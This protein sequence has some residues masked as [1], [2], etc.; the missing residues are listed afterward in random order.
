LPPWAHFPSAEETPS[1]VRILQS[2]SGSEG[3]RFIPTS[4][5]FFIASF[6]IFAV[7]LPL[8]TNVVQLGSAFFWS[9]SVSLGFWTPTV[10]SHQSDQFFYLFFGLPSV[11]R[12]DP[13][14][15]AEPNIHTGTPPFI[16]PRPFICPVYPFTSWLI[17]LPPR[18]DIHAPRCGVF[19]T[20]FFPGT[21]PCNR[22]PECIHST[23]LDI[24]LELC[25]VMLSFE[26]SPKSALFFGC[27]RGAFPLDGDMSSRRCFFLK[28]NTPPC[29]LSTLPSRPITLS[30]SVLLVLFFLSGT[31]LFSPR[32]YGWDFPHSFKSTLTFSLSGPTKRYP[33]N[34]KSRFAVFPPSP[35]FP[36]PFFLSPMDLSIMTGSIETFFYFFP[37][38]FFTCLR[39]L[40]RGFLSVCLERP[41]FSHP[42]RFYGCLYR[43]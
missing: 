7:W 22:F 16:S 37:P 1:S 10:V 42:A 41:F 21:H 5:V 18:K 29:F 33:I 17:F 36:P 30:R 13:P 23:F 15:N 43:A 40:P 28:K 34:L 2:P 12:K 27:P 4:G 9:P 25:C 14:L 35:F 31:H 20:F 11:P 6:R 32:H 19:P 26:T 39:P 24:P 3:V 8:S 38:D